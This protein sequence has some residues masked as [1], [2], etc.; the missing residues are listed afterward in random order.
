M[1][2]EIGSNK[3]QK[4]EELAVDGQRHLEGTVEAAHQIL[5]SMNQE[6]CNPSL[7]VPPTTRD[8]DPSLA[9]GG[10]GGGGGALDDARLRYKKSVDSLR[11]VISLISSSQTKPQEGDTITGTDNNGDQVEIQI[12]EQRA[13]ELRENHDYVCKLKKALYGLKQAPC[14]W[15]DRL[16]KYLQQQGFKR[17]MADNNLY[18]KEEDWGGSVDDKKITSG[19]AFFF[20]SYLVSWLSKNKPSISSSTVE[21]KYIAVVSCCTQVLWMKQTLLDIKEVTKKNHHLKVLID[22]LRDLVSDISMWQSPILCFCLNYKF[23]GRKMV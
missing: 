13:S 12:L 1:R 14:A 4:S 15:Y 6:L 11:D 23:H 8:H 18:V 7:W 5:A 16:D 19:G 17:G 22:Q 10:S 2:E 9:A 20:G 21:A 3:K